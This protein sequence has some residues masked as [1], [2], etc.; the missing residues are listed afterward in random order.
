MLVVE[1][2]KAR[3]TSKSVFYLINCKLLPDEN[4]LKGNEMN[5]NT[6]TCIGKRVLLKFGN[7]YSESVSEYK[8][9]EVSPSGNWIKIMNLNGRKFW[10]PVVEVAFIEELKSLEK[11][12]TG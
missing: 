7:R 8:I 12:P 10:K 6:D 9:I 1:R 4:R 3:I 11:A 5:L 2:L